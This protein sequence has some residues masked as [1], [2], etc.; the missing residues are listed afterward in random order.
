[1]LDSKLLAI[2]YWQGSNGSLLLHSSVAVASVSKTMTCSGTH[3]QLQPLRI[4]GTILSRTSLSFSICLSG[5]AAL[6][7]T[8][9]S[10]TL[11]ISHHSIHSVRGMMKLRPQT[12]HWVP[13]ESF[14]VVAYAKRSTKIA[15]LSSGRKD[16]SDGSWVVREHASK[17]TSNK[18]GA[19]E[20]FPPRDVGGWGT[21]LESATGTGT[22]SS[23]K[24]GP[25]NKFPLISRYLTS[26]RAWYVTFHCECQERRL[27]SGEMQHT[28]PRRGR[29]RPRFPIPILYW[30]SSRSSISV[31]GE[32]PGW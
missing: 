23:E 15:G 21:S 31:F 24:L 32:N 16:E 14:L 20:I 10:R 25:F 29:A 28:A 3:N 19:R 2:T 7:I 5:L 6:A 1:M 18:D 4:S 22:E 13:P 8:L 27:C 12:V 26:L 17:A 30:S 11:A 9:R